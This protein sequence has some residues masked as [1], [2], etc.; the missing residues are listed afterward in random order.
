[1]ASAWRL[2]HVTSKGCCG[3]MAVPS[4]R[5]ENL[6]VTAQAAQGPELMYHFAV[7]A[8]LARADLG[9]LHSAESDFV[10]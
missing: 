8:V 5:V 9:L 3:L 1:M 6:D 7:P 2:D 4:A 10:P